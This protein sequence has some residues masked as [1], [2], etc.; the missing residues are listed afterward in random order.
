MNND[1]L[2]IEAQ[3]GD[4][5]CFPLAL[6]LDTGEVVNVGGVIIGVKDGKTVILDIVIIDPNYADMFPEHWLGM[7]FNRYQ[8]VTLEAELVGPGETTEAEG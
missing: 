3:E 1:V 6:D 2:P 7:S 5:I 4:R 8:E